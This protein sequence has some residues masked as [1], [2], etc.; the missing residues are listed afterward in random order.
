MKEHADAAS[1][2][3]QQRSPRN[4]SVRPGKR[5]REACGAAWYDL[6]NPT[7]EEDRFVESEPRHRY[8][9]ARGDEGHRAIGSA[10]QGGRRRVHDHD[11]DGQSRHRPAGEKPGHLR[12]QGE[13]PGHRAL[14]RSEAVQAVSACAPASRASL[15]ARR[16]RG[17]HARAD[18]CVHRPPGASAGEH[19]R[20]DRRR[21]RT[22][23]SAAAAA[24][25]SASRRTCSR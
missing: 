4:R 14:F 17:R 11:G 20:R 3:Q 9:D 2:C 16:R 12:A 19:Q 15:P 1:F 24:A 22:R 6:F 21:S 10:V 18:G 13:H 5:A 25:T 23:S 8:P 7:P